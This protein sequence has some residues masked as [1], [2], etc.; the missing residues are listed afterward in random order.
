LQILHS[1]EC[2]E[3][4]ESRAALPDIARGEVQRIWPMCCL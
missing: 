4:H 2:Q 3:C 1:L